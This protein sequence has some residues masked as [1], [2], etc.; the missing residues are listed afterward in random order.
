MDFIICLAL[1]VV[2]VVLY[3]ILSP[4]VIG[5]GWSFFP[6]AGGMRKFRGYLDVHSLAISKRVPDEVIKQIAEIAYTCSKVPNNTPL[7]FSADP[8]HKSRM[9]FAEV[10]YK[11]ELGSRTHSGVASPVLYVITL[12]SVSLLLI[13]CIEKNQFPSGDD[14]PDSYIL[15]DEWLKAC[16]VS[17]SSDPIQAGIFYLRHSFK[18][19]SMQMSERIPD[20]VCREIAEKA[21]KQR[22][23]L[24]DFGLPNTDGYVPSLEVY[25]SMLIRRL[26]SSE[27]TKENASC[28]LLIDESWLQRCGVHRESGSKKG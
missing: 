17:N 21:L 3:K 7:L 15:D 9:V 16:G 19:H 23:N 24:Q 11:V 14:N 13:E 5:I 2:V 8:V 1:V 20:D 10:R 28:F 25:G 18:L 12:A 6:I 27:M 22:G 4:F 26:E